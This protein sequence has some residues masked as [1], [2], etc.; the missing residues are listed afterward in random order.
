MNTHLWIGEAGIVLEF[1]G[2]VLGVWFAWNTRKAW[3]FSEGAIIVEEI[4][5]RYARARKEFQSQFGNQAIAFSLIGL[6]LVLQF[7]GNLP[8]H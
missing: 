7:V 2:A 3:S 8:N 1:V 5:D 6:G 4:Y